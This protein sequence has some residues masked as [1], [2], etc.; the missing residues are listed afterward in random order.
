MLML[1][2][3]ID[4]NQFLDSTEIN[5]ILEGAQVWFST[6][7]WSILHKFR[8]KLSVCDLTVPVFSLGNIIYWVDNFGQWA[9]LIY[10]VDKII[11]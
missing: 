2:E 10:W 1:K 3:H 8:S 4:I 9:G 5:P 7:D 6:R 11:N